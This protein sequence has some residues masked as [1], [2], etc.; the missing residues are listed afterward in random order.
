MRGFSTV[1]LTLF[2]AI[3]GSGC[4]TGENQPG[5]SSFVN[6]YDITATCTAAA[7][8][9]SA[10]AVQV[11]I[12]SDDSS[13]VARAQIALLG[14]EGN[15]SFTLIAEK[16]GASFVGTY[17]L[18]IDDTG[19]QAAVFFLESDV[20]APLINTNGLAVS[21]SLNIQEGAANQ[22]LVTWTGVTV[23]VVS[24]EECAVTQLCADEGVADPRVLAGCANVIDA[25]SCGISE[26]LNCPSAIPDLSIGVITE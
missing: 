19:T 25:P 26:V 18:A 17:D 1:A 2:A 23:S 9:F 11:Q 8:E 5:T 21:G 13:G 3:S 12:G 4:L 20:A 10:P 7:L 24:K 6:D 15:R 22:Y 16:A 14:A